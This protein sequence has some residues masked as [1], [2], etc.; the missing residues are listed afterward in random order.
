MH[1]AKAVQKVVACKEA[2][3]IA[4]DK[5]FR[6]TLGRVRP[7]LTVRKNSLE[8]EETPAKSLREE[9]EQEWSNWEK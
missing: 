1:L 7:G 9:F 4:Y 2:I 3:W 8:E 5:L 6:D